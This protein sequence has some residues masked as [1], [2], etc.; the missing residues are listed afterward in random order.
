M[1]PTIYWLDSRKARIR[2]KAGGKASNLARLSLL[3]FPVPRGFV[4]PPGT[5][6][7]PPPSFG[8]VLDR[9]R[10]QLREPLAVRSS[11]V[12]ED[13]LH[14]SFAG[15]LETVL[16]VRGLEEL[17]AAIQRVLASV[18][19]PGLLTYA[20]RQLHPSVDGTSGNLANSPF[21][22]AILVQEMVPAVAA[23][24]AFSADPL[25]GRSTVIV[26]AVPR[27]GSDLV[28]GRAVP[29][30]F[31]VDPRG[32]LTLEDRPTLS[33][34]DFPEGVVTRLSVMVRKI[35]AHFGT[36]QDVE[37][38]W[39]GQDLFILQARPITSLIGQN[40]YSKK[41]VGDMAPGPLRQ[42]VWS[43]NTVGMAEG[44]FGQ[45]FTY[46]IG[47]NDYDFRR[48]LKRIR[49]R[50]YVNTTFVGELLAEIGLP[51]NL[52]EAM[53]REEKVPHPFRLNLKLLSRLP[54]VLSLALRYFQ[55]DRN[56]ESLLNAH[57]EALGA[58]RGQDWST[59]PR[60][61]LLARAQELLGLHRR[62][63][64]LVMFGSM[65][66]AV[67]TRLL[68][69]FVARHAPEVDSAQL[70]LG[71]RGLKS[72]EPNRD[73]RAVARRAGS[74]PE[75]IVSLLRSGKD[76]PIRSELSGSETG[77]RLLKDVDA[78]LEQYGFLS[79]NGTNFGEPS[80]IEEPGPLWMALG[81]MIGRD[82]SDVT[83]SDSIR[84]GSRKAVLE[85][86]GPLRRRR[87]LRRLAAAARYLELRERA[88]ILMTRDTYQLRRLFLA[89]GGR[90]AKDGILDDPEDVFLLHLHE[91]EDVV[92]GA[93]APVDLTGLIRD[94]AAEIAADRDVNL[95]ETILG[96][97]V[98][99][100]GITMESGP[101]L[102]GIG[103]SA[104]VIRGQARVVGALEDAPAHL[105][106]QDI[107][108]VPFSDVGWTPLFA[109][110]GGVVAECGGQLSH[111]AIVAREYG[112]PA[113]VGV[114]GA[115]G[116]IR[117]GQTI[118]VDG[119]GGKVIL[120][121]TETDPPD[122]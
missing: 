58:F 27:L 100:A 53:A 30:R 51:R 84:E 28:Q 31:V 80:W 57:E 122:S 121:E 110:V 67:R 120:I 104:G 86:L 52:F 70:L 119:V 11:L 21:G 88:S 16:E 109:T 65:N 13:G 14:Q 117:D 15:Q 85:R 29:N 4:L 116:R 33:S 48:I 60:R 12:G 59:E 68:K 77:R 40:V 118:S 10:R 5:V 94:R 45:V 37:W 1:K 99:T 24:V 98:P 83:D 74:L 3:G 76:T 93:G 90:L 26:E 63:Q 101:I 66:L 73:L 36:P 39:D 44:V 92:K 19:E 95:P 22:M 71:L 32:V 91:L 50:A 35:A 17:N 42:L 54:G 103:V 18:A 96:D 81:R 20:Q 69:R 87:F 106:D 79:S 49:S 113:V 8:S 7:A 107:L 41:L 38:A 105:T 56:A 112:L 108:V 114:Q 78:F 55:L 64:G 62:L 23:G 61:N 89:L 25:T 34:Q 9:S 72:L 111:T 97:A 102:T 43:T 82:A 75:E 47:K 6:M 115:M 46:L 2:E